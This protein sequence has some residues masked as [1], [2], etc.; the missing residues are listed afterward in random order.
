[1]KKTDWEKKSSVLIKVELAK[2]DMTYEDL[3]LALESR[4]ITY[5]TGNLIKK[6]NVGKF[7]LSFFLQCCDALNI[8]KI[9]L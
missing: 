5:N 9:D 8:Q 2:K 3:R 6:I 4:E 1:M 7:S